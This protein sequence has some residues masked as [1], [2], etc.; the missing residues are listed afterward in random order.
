[1]LVDEDVP[2]YF[3]ENGEIVER[4]D[5]SLHLLTRHELDDHLDPFL[6]RLVEILILDI[7]WRFRHN[8]LL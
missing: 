5:V 7:E 2:M 8:P 4:F 1:M 6:A 3:H